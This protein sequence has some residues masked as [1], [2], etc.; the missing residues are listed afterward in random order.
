VTF[1]VEDETR[2]FHLDPVPRIITAAE[3][4][5]LEA[6]L[7]QRARA[8]NAFIADAYGERRIVGAGV[9]PAHVIDGCEHFEPWM[10]DVHV[11]YGHATVTG[12]DVVRGTDGRLRVLEDNLRTPS[13][14]A[15]ASAARRVVDAQLPA[16]A[17]VPKRDVEGCFAML[18]QA[19]RAA[20]P[21]GGRD[22]NLVL[23]TDGTDN[24][25][26][27]E[28]RTLARRLNVTV[29]A[30]RDLRTRNGRLY[31]AL[32]SG[33]LREVQVVYRRT[34]QDRLS[35]DDGRPTW[36]AE[37]LLE[38]LRRGTVA[39]LN[40]PGSGVA[41]DKLVH[42][43][44]EDMV[45]FYLD[46]QPLV[47]SVRTYDLGR[48]DERTRALGRLGALVVK[49]RAGYGGRGVVICGH[50]SEAD[51]ELAAAAIRAAP[52]RFIAQET[53]MLS[54]HPT[55]CDGRLEPR[56]VDLRVFAIA[57]DQMVRVVPGG[58]TRVALERGSLIVNSSQNGGGKDT[59]VLA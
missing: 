19:L 40:A 5:R 10:I 38:P 51:R 52:E 9:V 34:D 24:S 29:V 43:Y 3:W 57:S 13:G 30:P 33:R 47:E 12:F 50:A 53:V 54:R 55:I 56:H 28:H 16:A 23:L 31:V 41:D 11:P 58:L 18:E 1:R 49:P 42:A 7:A 59:W 35:D 17:Q 15:Y 26:W 22:A 4:S 21:G 14:F 45:R 48:P 20:V 25:A 37:V 8:L 27:Y 44:V 39:V 2:R 32:P 46:E 6:G 36:L